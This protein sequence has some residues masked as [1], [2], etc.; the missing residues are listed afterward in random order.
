LSSRPASATQQDPA[1]KKQK[2]NK[3]KSCVF[4]TNKDYYWQILCEILMCLQK[5]SDYPRLQQHIKKILKYK[6]GYGGAHRN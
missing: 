5:S 1:S 2:Q 4:F 3:I 6:T